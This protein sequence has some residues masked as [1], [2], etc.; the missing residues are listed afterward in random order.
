ML[1]NLD[2]ALMLLLAGLL[3]VAIQREVWVVRIQVETI[4][5]VLIG[6]AI[7]AVLLIGL[8]SALRADG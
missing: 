2:I 5:Q 4:A 7:L 3:I 6:S 8:I 1:L